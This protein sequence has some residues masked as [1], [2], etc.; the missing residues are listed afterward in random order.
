LRLFQV[1][2]C[3]LAIDGVEEN[4]ETYA[5]TYGEI[6]VS[7][8]TGTI[9]RL[10]FRAGLSYR[11]PLQHSDI[12]VEYGPVMLGGTTRI[13]PIRSVGISRQ[14]SIVELAEFG[15]KFKV[16]APFE[17][18]LNDVKYDNYHLFQSTSRVLPGFTEAPITK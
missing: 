17:T 1:G 7:P 8:A 6:A 2:F 18:I 10:T 9:M 13:C 5:P 3:C 16:Y 15:G 14:R 4:F 11:L 12:M